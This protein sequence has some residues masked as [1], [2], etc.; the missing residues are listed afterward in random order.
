VSAYVCEDPAYR[1]SDLLIACG[2][3]NVRVRSLTWSRWT[4]DRA[5]GTGVWSQNDCVPYCAAGRFHD[6]PVRLELDEPMTLQ[7]KLVFG[8]VTAYFPSSAPEGAVD[9]REA[10]TVDGKYPE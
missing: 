8:N 3:G 2:D 5:T 9:G 6:F 10:V 4:H 7:G 1:P